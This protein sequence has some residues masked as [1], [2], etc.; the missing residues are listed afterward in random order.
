M[1]I[2]VI[3]DSAFKED[4][5]LYNKNINVIPTPQKE[6]GI[7][8][9]DTV[10][11]N[12]IGSNNEYAS[13]QFD[14]NSLNSFT[15]ISR[16]RN[17]IYQTLDYM[18]ED[19]IIAAVLE[20]YA[21]DATETNDNGDIVW[22]ESDEA[23]VAKYITYLL[24][25]LGINK[26]VYSWTHALC[27]YGDLYVRL[28]RES[29]YDN[30]LFKK[31]KPSA[32]VRTTID[33]EE[34][35]SENTILNEDVKIKVYSKHDKYVHYVEMCQ[36]PAQ[37]FELTRFGKTVAYIQTDVQ[38][39]AT[40]TE[41]LSSNT[42]LNRYSFN[43]SD[44]QLYQPTEFVH[45]S[46]SDNTTRVAEEVDL[47]IKDDEQ[48]QTKLTYKVRRGQSLLFNDYKIWRQLQ[49]LENSVL[50]N[51]LTQSSIVRV[52]GVEVGD[53]PKESVGLHIHGIKQMIEQKSALDIGKSM[54]DYTNPGPLVNNI[55]VPTRNNQGVI[56]TQQIGGDVDI[57]SLADLDYYQSKLFG[58]LRIPKQ[59][60]GIT[61][62]N[63]GFSGGQSLAI[64]S[65]RYAKMVKRIQNVI[66]Q[67]VTD[68]INLI[69]IDTKNANYINKFV[70]KMLP[71]TTQEEVDRRENLSNKVGLISDI[72]NVLS[73]IE[74]PTTKLKILKSL[75]SGTITNPEVIQLIQDEIELME[76]QVESEA[77][78]T[79]DEDELFDDN[80]DINLMSSG[81]SSSSSDNLDALFGSDDTLDFND[82]LTTDTE[83]TDTT[84]EPESAALPSPAD[85]NIGDVSDL[86]N[87]NLD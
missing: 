32:N 46:L 36:N 55:Y 40:T 56:S 12:I 16:N 45:A 18:A 27:K 84:T 70:I 19:S 79:S 71:P 62:D 3:K 52:I 57:K 26:N 35:L 53:M 78:S 39:Q 9:E 68:I 38:A 2:D 20:T 34:I 86:T 69:L 37:I 59:Y 80:E 67:L 4:E 14:V 74:S 83:A 30:V 64:I 22:V 72:M 25:S 42:F 51:R 17:E 58:S 23:D 13:S 50:L 63:A 8:L 29:E 31:D 7:D 47:F 77:I 1:D 24:N 85:L 75:L 87:P 49:L 41:A 15:Q 66:C 81:G 10:L 5:S 6:I 28:Y 76:A 60:F 82:D 65:S 21:E 33:G 54:N 11:K 73:D 44:V 43:Q 48:E 61:D